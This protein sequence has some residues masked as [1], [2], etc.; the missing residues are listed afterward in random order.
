MACL[1]TVKT[2][3][4]W[5]VYGGVGGYLPKSTEDYPPSLTCAP[6][7]CGRDSCCLLLLSSSMPLVRADL[8]AV[9]SAVGAGRVG[10]ARLPK[11]P[12][13]NLAR[14]RPAGAVGLGFGVLHDEGVAPQQPFARRAQAPA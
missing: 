9:R 14:S 11:R 1:P 5:R 2:M 12:T 13:P 4:G 8:A 7:G 10:P 6:P 3:E